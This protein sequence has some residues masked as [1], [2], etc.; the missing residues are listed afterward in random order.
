L[1]GVG[2]INQF[3]AK[4]AALAEQTEVYFTKLI[5]NVKSDFE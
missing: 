5:K 3:G 2:K 1:Q 4:Y